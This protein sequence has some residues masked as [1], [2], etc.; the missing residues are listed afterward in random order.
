MAE[1]AFSSCCERGLLFVAVCRLLTGVASLIVEHGLEG[2]RASV[3]V[4]RALSS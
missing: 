2:T 3:G 1:Q 4:A